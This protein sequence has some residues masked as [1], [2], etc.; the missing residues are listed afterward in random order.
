M[1]N[2]YLQDAL[3]KSLDAIYE[4]SHTSIPI[5]IAEEELSLSVFK[6]NKDLLV[7][8]LFEKTGLSEKMEQN[9]TEI[10]PQ[11]IEYAEKNGFNNLR[12]F[13]KTAI[14]G[15]SNH[16]PDKMNM[17]LELP[18]D[19]DIIW[20]GVKGTI[21]NRVRRPNKEGYHYTIRS[22]VSDLEIFY[23]IYCSSIHYIG[24]LILPFSFFQELFDN[25][26][27]HINIHIGYLNDKPVCTAFLTDCGDEMFM[28]WAGSIPE[29]NRFGVNMA[30]YWNM[31]E[32]S[33][34]QG[35]KRLN[36]GRSTRNEGTYRF[37]KQWLADE[38]QLY[39]YH[40]PIYQESLIKNKVYSQ[41]SK[42]ITKSP[43]FVMNCASK[44]FVKR[45]Y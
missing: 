8:I 40:L 25:F 18:E 41:I 31:I 7:G 30:M 26:K 33:I 9:M 37:K 13:S 2:I 23:K 4:T 42:S 3:A 39:M 17:M 43:D 5:C 45:F 20:K 32:W 6:K 10:V 15:L 27:E 28:P 16:M 21:R 24:S 35:K 14:M 12:I 34:S 22:D 1:N 36:L 19:A 11:V 38:Q 29:Y 44:L